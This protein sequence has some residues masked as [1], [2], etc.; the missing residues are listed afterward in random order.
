[1]HH[2]YRLDLQ[3][4]RSNIDRLSIH[5]D[6]VGSSR[7]FRTGGGPYPA[8]ASVGIWDSDGQWVEL[9]G[10]IQMEVD[11]GRDV[12]TFRASGRNS[13]VRSVR[14]TVPRAA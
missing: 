8:R 10:Q 6:R 2:V 3:V 12:I 1:M 7:T 4:G 13:P 5:I 9:Q 14:I 11:A